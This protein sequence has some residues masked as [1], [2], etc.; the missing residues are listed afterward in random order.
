MITIQSRPCR[1]RL[2]QY[3]FFVLHPLIENEKNG[4][5]VH[6]GETKELAMQIK[7]L[8]VDPSLGIR[9]GAEARKT[10]IRQ[11]HQDQNN[12]KMVTLFQT[13]GAIS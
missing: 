2:N 3:H 5:L 8:I 13:Q 11:Y 10:I 1:W 9:L 6:A 4:L 12:Q 7:R